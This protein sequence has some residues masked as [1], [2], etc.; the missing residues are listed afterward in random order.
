M[1]FQPKDSYVKEQDPT[2]LGDILSHSIKKVVL[3]EDQISGS[4]F[5]AKRASNRQQLER[6]EIRTSRVQ[7]AKVYML[8]FNFSS[9]KTI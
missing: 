3:C 6:S 8:N 5:V 7:R 4:F 2:N 1:K 9:T